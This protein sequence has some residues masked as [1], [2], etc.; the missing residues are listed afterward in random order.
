MG[1]S[2]SSF[3]FSLLNHS[4]H[5]C[6]FSNLILQKAIET[7]EHKETVERV[8]EVFYFLLKMV[9]GSLPLLPV[10]M[11]FDLFLIK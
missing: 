2:F 9:V 4:L 1:F 6:V 3:F 8:Q 10:E 7:K 11:V 5:F